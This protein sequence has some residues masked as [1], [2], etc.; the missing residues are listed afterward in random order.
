MKIYAFADESSS[1]IKG[2]INALKR[3]HLDGLEIR[4]VEGTNISKISEE[5]AKE[6]KNSFDEEGLEIWSI[7]SP[8]GKVD[9]KTYD[10]N[11]HIET[12]KHTL[13]IA[14]ILDAKNIRIFSFYTP[15]G[16]NIDDYKDEIIDRLGTFLNIASR[17]ELD[18]CHENEKGIFGED[19]KH[20]KM[21]LDALPELKGIFDP[22]NF[23]QCN[24]D[25]IKAWEMLKSRIKY[26]HIKD[27]IKGG[28]V[29]P[30]GKG[31]GNLPYI[32]KDF[33]K[34]G[35]DHLTIEPHLSLFDGLATLER[36]GEKSNIGNFVYSS[37]EEAFD[38]A[39]NAL[40]KLI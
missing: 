23:V 33:E 29:V 2:Q 22:A 21:I 9:I 14:K 26:L 18:L 38:E 20:C 27:C 7:G 13:E 37:K 12:F 1:L 15:K 30:A 4:D 31:D 16:E 11:T 34:L 40:K 32:I 8:I 17:Y 3:N 39:C 5:K 10:F 24:V 36:E 35:G 19:D 25:T 28:N 6:I